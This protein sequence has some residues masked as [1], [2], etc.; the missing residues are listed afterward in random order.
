LTG[1]YLKL[2]YYTTI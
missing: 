1:E 2:S